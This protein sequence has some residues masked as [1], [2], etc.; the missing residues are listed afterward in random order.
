VST[1]ASFDLPDV[2][3]LVALHVP[4]HEH[5]AAAQRWFDGTEAFATT[6]ITEIGL[7][8]L[9]LAPLPT[10]HATLD[11]VLA[12]LDTLASDKRARFLPD[13]NPTRSTGRFTYSVTGHRQVTDIHL[14]SL[15]AAHGGR[16]VTL[17]RKIAAGLRLTDRSAVHVLA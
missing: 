8:R 13:D 10:N 14:V 6:P 11:Q 3:V 16:L 1:P 7:M 15:A 17:D 5:R 9:L 4:D 12:A 2:N